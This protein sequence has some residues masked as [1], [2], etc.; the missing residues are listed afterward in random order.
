MNEP[1]CRNAEKKAVRTQHNYI[2]KKKAA[3]KSKAPFLPRPT[4]HA[5]YLLPPPHKDFKDDSCAVF[6]AT[7]LQLGGKNTS[8][9]VE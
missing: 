5:Y 8:A 6:E 3:Q 1:L 2:V 9:L 4:M 7:L